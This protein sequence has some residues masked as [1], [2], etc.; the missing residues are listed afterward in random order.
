MGKKW[1]VVFVQNNMP[2][3]HCCEHKNLEMTEG[4]PICVDCDKSWFEKDDIRLK[5]QEYQ[6]GFKS[7]VAPCNIVGPHTHLVEGQSFPCEKAGAGISC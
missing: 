1:D 2:C 6:N 7:N 3:T 5:F 4:H